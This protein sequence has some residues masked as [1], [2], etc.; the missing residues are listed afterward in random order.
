MP[1]KRKRNSSWEFIV[2]RKGVLPKPLY[3]T[4][5]NEAEGDEYCRRLE[6]LLDR[7]IVPDEF[8][9]RGDGIVSLSDAISGYR[10]HVALPKSDERLLVSILAQ[11]GGDRISTIDYQWCERWVADMKRK[12]SLAPS[13]VRH[14]VGAL[15]RCL[16][17]LSRKHADIFPGN[18]LRTLPKGDRVRL[19]FQSFPLAGFPANLNNI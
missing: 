18:P 15:A 7:G 16:D 9:G 4:F 11:K 1:A 13:T 17:W 14:N 3:L 12:Q 10:G 5:S 8:R 6:A 2:R 19:N